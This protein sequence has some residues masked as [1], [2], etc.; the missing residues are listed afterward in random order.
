M[1]ELFSMRASNLI[2]PLLSIFAAALLTALFFPGMMSYDSIYQYRQVIG[3]VPVT[4]DH[5]PV[6]VHLWRLAHS[7]IPSPGALLL[8]H[9]AVYWAAAAL[10]AWGVVSTP[11]WRIFIFLL[12]G[13]WPPLLIHSVHLWKDSGMMI[14][15]MACV[16][17]LMQT[18]ADQ[19]RSSFFSPCAACFTPLPFGI[20]RLPG[21]CHWRLVSPGEFQCAWHG[22]HNGTKRMVAREN[23][24]AS[25]S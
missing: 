13:C 25:A 5:P 15:M 9:Q 12:V 10:F 21:Q 22:I 7:A 19:E 6:M 3:A 17:L 11:L 23:L 16:S 1:R 20:M 2:L 18:P 14:A 24:P 4:N 8:V